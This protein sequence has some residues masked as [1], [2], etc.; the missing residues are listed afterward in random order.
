[1]ARQIDE[2]EVINSKQRRGMRSGRAVI[3]EGGGQYGVQH[4]HY[5]CTRLLRERGRW[6]LASYSGRLEG[7]CLAGFPRLPRAEGTSCVKLHG[8]SFVRDDVFTDMCFTSFECKWL[9]ERQRQVGFG[10]TEEF[11]VFGDAVRAA[12]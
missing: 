10:Y 3:R 7:N 5:R 11:V 6:L 9:C 1:M 8:A 4:G 12:Q 2:A